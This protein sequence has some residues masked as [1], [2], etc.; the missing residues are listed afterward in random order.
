MNKKQTESLKKSL[1][2][3]KKALMKSD[4]PL[5]VSTE[6]QHYRQSRIGI[7]KIEDEVEISLVKEVDCIREYQ[8]RMKLLVELMI[9]QEETNN[10][11]QKQL[12]TDIRNKVTYFV[13]KQKSRIK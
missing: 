10:Q 1:I 12:V 13:F 5:K 9:K 2:K 3:L 4:E 8:Q 7:D 6:C 11:A